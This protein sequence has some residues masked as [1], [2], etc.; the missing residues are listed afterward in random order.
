MSQKA[1][2]MPAAIA[3]R[4]A[5]GLLAAFLLAATWPA[6]A[7]LRGRVVGV[8]D[9][10]SIEVLAGGRAEEVRLFGIDCP[11][12]NQPFGKQAKRFT[13]SAV[14]GKEVVVEGRGRD[15]YGRLLGV[16]TLPDGKKLNE[17][18]V[19]A[20]LAWWYYSYAP[21]EPGLA[22]LE[23]EA[24]SARRGLWADRDPVPPWAWR[25]LKNSRS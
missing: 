12:M 3:G 1:G 9:G 2:A 17:E 22:L 8:K 16:V 13:S 4:A 11:E 25:K 18:L 24:Q 5:S 7:E 19:R 23:K 10:D 14:F 20:G 21:K 15:R 6:P